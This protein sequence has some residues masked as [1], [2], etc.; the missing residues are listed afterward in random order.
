MFGILGPVRVVDGA[1]VDVTPP[2]PLQRRLLAMLLLHRGRPVHA[3]LLADALWPDQLPRDHLAA[4][5]TH[6]FRLRRLLP[7]GAIRHQPPGYRF[8]LDGAVLDADEFERAVSAGVAAMAA[9]AGG[10]V[11]LLEGALG[12]WRGL[13]F[14]EL[15]EVDDG[16]IE[17]TRL[18]ELHARAQEER[19]GALVSCRRH[20][21]A[22]PELEALVAREPLRERPR[23][24]LLEAL[25][26]TGRRAEALRTVD[27][28]RRRLAAELGMDPSA[29][30]LARQ[31]AL[32]VGAEPTAPTDAAPP[33]RPPSSY[34]GGEA[35]LDR[36]AGLLGE[37]RV[38]TLV[39]PGGV[40]KTRTA[41]EVM[42]LARDR[43]PDGTVFCDLTGAARDDLDAVVAVVGA[44]TGV[45]PRAGTAPV[46][47]LTEVLRH[48]HLL[49]VLDNVEHVLEATATFVERLLATS[50]GPSVLA[51][52][53]ERLAVDGECV[54]P[55]DPLPWHPGGEQ[56]DHQEAPAVALF[57]ARAGAVAPGFRLD[58]RTR[59]L[60]TEICRRLDG[61]PLAIELAA[62]R[63]R[64]LQ[65]E[66][67]RDGLD[68]SLTLLTGGRRA[69]GRHRSLAAALLW[70]YDL[71]S[72]PEREMLR[73]V[74]VFAA[75]FSAADAA[76]VAGT[77]HASTVAVLADLVE[78]SLVQRTD[79]RF[80]LLETVR[81]F[82]V[83]QVPQELGEALAD[84][85]SSR[86]LAV[87][88]EADA[89]LRGPEAAVAIER[90]RAAVPDLRLAF[91]HAARAADADRALALTTAV[92]D[93]ALDAGL[94]EL[95]GWAESAAAMPGAAHHPLLPDVLAI[96]AL[97]AWKSGDLAGARRHLADAEA[98]T[99]RLGMEDRCLVLDMLGTT[100]MSTGDLAA[101]SAWY[102]RALAAAEARDDPLRRAETGATVAC[103]LAYGRRQGAATTQAD[104]LLA[105][106]DA[107]RAP[108]AAAWAWY[109][110]GEAM[111]D[112]DPALARSRLSRAVELARA[113]G[114][115][116]VEGVAGASLASLD[117]RHGTAA[118]AVAH[119]R[120]LLPLWARAG[121]GAPFWTMVRSVAELLARLG[122]DRD[123]ALL[124]G[125]AA[126][127]DRGTEVFGPEEERLRT[128][129]TQLS[130][131]LGE[132]GYTEALSA[133]KEL[134]EAAAAAV[135]TAAFL[136]SSPT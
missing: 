110:A 50:D 132:R 36:A 3:D 120:R 58:D 6:V 80:A 134:D 21:E 12:W 44:A 33:P 54:H 62:T 121:V 100:A 97:G 19:L 115:T 77:T 85:H 79:G 29:A 98:A 101:A 104:A 53:R 7:A 18:E 4:L 74:S 16:R 119:Y 42:H 103:V 11:T 30:L 57:V 99:R 68:H 60:V 24:L 111:L 52:G 8:D 125:A 102:R 48:Q 41:L 122:R 96:A 109:G 83:A 28:Y 129:G 130:V 22:I 27:D 136:E 106:V 34:I 87:A 73:S 35:L 81:R 86:M 32:L 17:A 37:H 94:P 76:A 47:R 124:L 135:A 128:L 89:A 72:S 126:A 15:G 20:G 26:A 65:L 107:G 51:T 38:V 45:E 82:A 108:L 95:L 118:D 49:L 31:H 13:P 93:V 59:P 67:I 23:E 63:L 133:G 131:R 56:G 91:D 46:D 2:G 64:S 55:V 116:F 123:A 84:R 92:R 88:Q 112:S 25:A 75:P 39:G 5:Q 105:D 69:V 43:F 10:A 113:T 40:G 61:L 66:E 14:T 78:R 117:V 71:L 1:G 70:S 114:A 90:I 9:D 127:P